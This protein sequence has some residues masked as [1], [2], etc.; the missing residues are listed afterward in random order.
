MFWFRRKYGLTPN[1]PRFLALTLDEIE[2]DYW[3]HHYAENPSDNSFED[4]DFDVDAIV[5][6]MESDDWETVI[7]E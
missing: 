2:T 4:D 7:N 1:D 3:A 6:A 5:D